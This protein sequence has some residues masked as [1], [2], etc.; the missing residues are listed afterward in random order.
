MTAM[1]TSAILWPKPA[2]QTISGEIMS[3]RCSKGIDMVGVGPAS[4]HILVYE[5]LSAAYATCIPL[6][7]AVWQ[8]KTGSA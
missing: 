8:C 2:T 5:H 4:E 6:Q 3:E 1:G 7:C